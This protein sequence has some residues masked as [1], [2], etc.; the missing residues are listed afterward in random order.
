MAVTAD[1]C[2]IKWRR[3]GG[4]GVDDQIEG[5]RVPA[6]AAVRA[7]GEGGSGRLAAPCAAMAAATAVYRLFAVRRRL[8]SASNV[9][10]SYI[11]PW[12]ICV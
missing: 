11:Y 4:E 9:F 12:R 5:G 3:R 1:G 2:S 6:T 7:S 8:G 10:G